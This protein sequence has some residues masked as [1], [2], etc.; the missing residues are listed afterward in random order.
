MLERPPSR[1]RIGSESGGG[2]SR[3]SSGALS[4]YGPPATLG[5]T[6]TSAAGLNS[7]RKSNGLP[8]C[9][10]SAPFPAQGTRVPSS[11]MTST[12]PGPISP[13]AGRTRLRR[14]KSQVPPYQLQTRSAPIADSLRSKY[15]A[16][17]PTLN[18]GLSG[19]IFL[20]ASPEAVE[21][22]EKEAPH[23]DETSI[24]WRPWAPFV[25]AVAADKEAG[26]ERGH[27][28]SI[29]LKPVFKVAAEALV[30][31]LI[32]VVDMG[33]PLQRVTRNVK[34]A[35]D[36]D[37]AADIQNEEVSERETVE[38]DEIWWSVHPSPEQLRNQREARESAR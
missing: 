26:L 9:L 30:E 13:S 34:G 19:D 17:K 24:L 38:L 11:L 33:T 14:G 28:D 31:S 5:A 16:L 23:T 32:D 35:K 3:D 15:A 6:T 1:P 8:S 36:L 22:F 4:L 21:S 29:W 37:G 10:L 2:T 27:E 25:L 20:C 18:S 12:K 7:R